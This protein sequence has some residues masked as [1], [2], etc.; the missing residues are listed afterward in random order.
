MCHYF[1]GE[2]QRQTGQFVEA[3]EAFTS[4]L[5]TRPGEL[6]ALMALGQTQ[7]DLG[8]AEELAGFAARA[9]A[10]FVAAIGAAIDAMQGSPGFRRMAWKIIG[11]ALFGL[12]QRATFALEDEVRTAL[13]SALEIL[14]P[15]PSPRLKALFVVSQGSSDVP[16]KGKAVLELAVSA[17]EYRRALG[18]REDP[19]Y[20]SSS[21]D[22]AV[23]LHTWARATPDPEKRALAEKEAVDAITAALRSDPGN[24]AYWITLG[25]IHFEKTP[26][27]AQHAYIRAVEIDK[28]VR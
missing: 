28:T 3:I 26:K 1:M 15:D 20:G 11:D 4:I 18:A 2:V 25:D 23:A 6:G 24:E 12:S 21:A 8:R 16:L 5:E 17:Y 13:N 10:S 19:S 14:G 7:L 22:L 27:A 9:E